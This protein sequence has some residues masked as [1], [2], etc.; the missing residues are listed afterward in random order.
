MHAFKDPVVDQ[1]E[2]AIKNCWYSGLTIK[3]T[4][5]RTGVD[6]GRVQ[7]LFDAWDVLLVAGIYQ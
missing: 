2:A 6:I 7:R 5:Q 4:A 3:A 1:I